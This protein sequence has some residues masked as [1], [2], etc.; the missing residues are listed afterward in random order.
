[1]IF[2]TGFFFADYV[3]RGRQSIETAVLLLAYKVRYP[4]NFF[5]LRGNHGLKKIFPLFLLGI[6]K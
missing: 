1:M 2:H 3:D 5:L 4:N 6:K